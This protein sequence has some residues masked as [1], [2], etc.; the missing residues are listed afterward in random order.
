MAAN[1]ALLACVMLISGTMIF[2]ISSMP[3]KT[4]AY[5]VRAPIV[6]VGDSDFTPA[7]GVVGGTGAIANPYIISGW[8]IMI[9][10]GTGISIS[11]TTAYFMIVDVHVNGT[12][13]YSGSLTGISFFSVENGQIK[14]SLINATNCAVDLQYSYDG[15]V[16]GN[17]FLGT[18]GWAMNIQNSN[19]MHVVDNY[20][21][22]Q[23][24]IQSYR[25]KYSNVM[26]NEF[27]MNEM[28]ISGTDANTLLVKENIATNCGYPISL[29]SSTNLQV[30]NN[31]CVDC[32]YGV[33]FSAVSYSDVRGNAI[34][35][36]SATGVSVWS[37]SYEIT[38]RDNLVNGTVVFGGVVV[39]DSWDVEITRNTVSNNTIGSGHTGG[40]IALLMGCH[41]IIVYNNSIVDNMPQLAEDRGGPENQWNGTYPVGG[42]YWSNYTGVDLMQGPNQD[43]PGSDGFGDSPLAID[44]DSMDYYPLVALHAGTVRPVAEFTIDPTL[45]DVTMII[46]FDATPSYHPEP[47]KNITGYRWDFDCDGRFDTGLSSNPVATHMFSVPGNYTV[48]LEVEDEDGMTD[49]T[50]HA[51][52]ILEGGIIPEFGAVL[53]PVLAVI[54][55]VALAFRRRAQGS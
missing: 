35:R 42:N 53:A 34:E 45:G 12:A 29:S 38:I 36:P 37:G 51:I 21:Q 19:R 47:T 20:F 41:D 5:T 14:G 31:L 49:M 23:N 44:A 11:D 50:T 1:F 32:M 13:T 17:E 52:T 8:H 16:Q 33:D 55:L 4:E 7:N 26:L 46:T 40:G 2:A 24:G 3:A 30:L 25:W 48:I 6:I 54:A 43:V 39:E 28:C 10:T 15:S 22:G 9:S 27:L 18:V